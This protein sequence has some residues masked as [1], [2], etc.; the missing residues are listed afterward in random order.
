VIAALDL[1]IPVNPIEKR[2]TKTMTE[3]RDEP[4]RPRFEPEII[5]PGQNRR[6][7]YW[8]R[9]DWQ[10]GATQRVYVARVGPFGVGALFLFVA[11]LLAL[12]FVAVIGALLI[13]IPIVA[14]IVVLGA[15]FRLW[16]R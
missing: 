8:P 15:I 6:Q 14:L 10:T 7:P 16:R 11:V 9:T 2:N 4:E 1:Y 5:P 12:T 3:D 13:W